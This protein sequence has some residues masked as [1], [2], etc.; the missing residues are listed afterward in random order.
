MPNPIGVLNR[1]ERRLRAVDFCVC[2]SMAD[3]VGRMGVGC[4]GRG[5]FDFGRAGDQLEC[6]RPSND[7]ITSR[8]NQANV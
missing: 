3:G 6:S 1:F 2:R 8:I 4:G 5:R 7:T